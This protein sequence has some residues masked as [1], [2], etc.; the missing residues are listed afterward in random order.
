MPMVTVCPSYPDVHFLFYKLLKKYPQ[1]H[2]QEQL[3]SKM[4]TALAKE[5]MEIRAFPSWEIYSLMNFFDFCMGEENLET[6]EC[7]FALLLSEMAGFLMNSSDKLHSGVREYIYRLSHAGEQP[8]LATLQEHYEGYYGV[9]VNDSKKMPNSTDSL[10]YTTLMNLYVLF[11]PAF[12]DEDQT[13]LD[14]VRPISAFQLPALS[15]SVV[16]DEDF[17]SLVANLA[18]RHLMNSDISWLLAKALFDLIGKFLGVKPGEVEDVVNAIAYNPFE[19]PVFG[20][21]SSIKDD[22]FRNPCEYLL[23]QSDNSGTAVNIWEACGSKEGKTDIC[24]WYC[25]TIVGNT[26]LQHKVKE[27]FEEALHLT[28][29][30]EPGFPQVLLPICRFPGMSGKMPPEKCWKKVVND[31]GVCYSSQT[32]NHMF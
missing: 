20:D 19:F 15:S 3:L 2:K 28:I 14:I 11:L 6:E 9:G 8:T 22:N 4:G 16:S 18:D 1:Y 5:D 17:P 7:Q 30:Q 27:L 21:I 25:E 31:H 10:H 13:E 32:G 29:S 26:T 12:V 24:T 23:S